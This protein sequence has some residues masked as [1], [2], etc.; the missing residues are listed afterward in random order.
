MVDTD[1]MLGRLKRCCALTAQCLRAARVVYAVCWW[2]QALIWGAS[3]F[4]VQVF[5]NRLAIT[6]RARARLC[7]TCL[8]AC[9]ATSSQRDWAIHTETLQHRTRLRA[10]TDIAA[11]LP[12]VTPFPHSMLQEASELLEAESPGC[13]P[14]GASRI[15]DRAASS[16]TADEVVFDVVI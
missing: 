4:R 5:G 14:C 9:D 2:Y 1:W 13:P 10:S 15:C 11:K 6:C 8:L 3:R 12:S 7:S 16:H